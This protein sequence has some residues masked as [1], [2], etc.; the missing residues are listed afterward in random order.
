VAVRDEDV[1]LAA[2][3][4]VT[5][6]L[7]DPPA[8]LLTVNHD[9]LLAAVQ[10]HPAGA[11][12][13]TEPVPPAAGIVN[14]PVDSVYVHDAPACVTATVFPATVRVALR[15]EVAVFAEAATFNVPLPDPL[16]PLVTVSHVALLAAV[17]VHPVGA[18]TVTEPLPPPA[19]MFSVVA[20]SV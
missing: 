5:A 15:D 18:V 13:V 14:T 19:T 17:H 8:P 12:T 6:P 4:T 1:V 10:L 16:P 11:V 2:P 3:T 7:P 20:D 9:A